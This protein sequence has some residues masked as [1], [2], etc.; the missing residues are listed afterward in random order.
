LEKTEFANL[1]NPQSL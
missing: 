1:L